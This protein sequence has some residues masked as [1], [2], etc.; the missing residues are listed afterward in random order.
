MR[1]AHRDR[2]PREGRCENP[3]GSPCRCVCAS[4]L[5]LPGATLAGDSATTYYVS[6]RQRRELPVRRRGGYATRIAWVMQNL[7]AILAEVK[8]AADP[9]VRIIGMNYYTVYAPLRVSDPSLVFVCSRLDVLNAALE[10]TCAAA[11]I[12]SPMSRARSRTTYSRARPP[13]S[14][15]G[16]DSALPLAGRAAV[17][18][19]V[20]RRVGFGFAVARRLLADGAGVLV[21]SW[22]AHDEAQPWGA[23]PAGLEGVLAEL[24]AAGGRVEQV[25]A[26]F[27]E[28]DAPA[29]VISAAT[30]VFGD[31]DILVVDAQ[32]ITG[33]VI[34]S[35]GGFRR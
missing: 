35:E 21:H 3:A 14:A 15:P 7:S 12:R 22:K 10:A 29:A 30:A 6:R 19:G 13:T 16:R 32:W 23:D 17:V 33:Q 8:A 34:N 26:E 18:T 27:A 5:F 25:E 4:A 20:S 1:R 24:G 11:G 9:H 31:V 2:R 28:A